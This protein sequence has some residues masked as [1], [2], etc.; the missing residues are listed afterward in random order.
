MSVCYAC[1]RHWPDCI[2]TLA[3]PPVFISDR[4][5][6][7]FMANY[8]KDLFCGVHIFLLLHKIRREKKT[9]H[10]ICIEEPCAVCHRL[11][12]AQSANSSEMIVVD[13]TALS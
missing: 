10:N 4:I 13:M 2:P 9:A 11:H 6:F 12:V 1:V 5:G 7:F 3:S 8:I